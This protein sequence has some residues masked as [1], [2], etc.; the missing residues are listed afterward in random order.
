MKLLSVKI[1]SKQVNRILGNAVSYSY[2]FLDGVDIQ[3][4]DFNKDLGEFITDALYKYIDSKAR[5]NPEALHHVYEWGQVGMPA[6]RLFQLSSKSSKRVITFTGKFL[7]SKSVSD[8]SNTPFTDKA[9]IMENSIDIVIEPKN[10]DVLA[11]ES[12]GEMFFTTNS[13]YIANPG[14]DA[15]AGSFGRTV[16]DFFSNYMTNALMKPFIDKL[17][18]PVEYTRDFASGTK[19]GKSAGVKAG[20]KYLNTGVVIE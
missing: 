14:G 2:G 5:V 10:S 9:N 20:K 3:Q 15:V 4:I 8:T 7:Q 19:T 12:N 16:E 17:S 13:I 6:G 18:N 1:D 11:F